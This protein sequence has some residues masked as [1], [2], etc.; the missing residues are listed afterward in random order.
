MIKLAL[1]GAGPIARNH[2]EVIK[3]IDELK[4]VGIVSRGGSSAKQL[5]SSYKIDFYGQKVDD[6][7]AK[8]NPDAILV[9]VSP[10][11][12]AKVGRDVLEFSLP[13]FFEKPPALRLKEAIDLADIA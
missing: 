13:V 3:S 8:S 4:A 1:I 5:A 11:Q 9:L 2:L 7:I 12:M 10:D 6:V